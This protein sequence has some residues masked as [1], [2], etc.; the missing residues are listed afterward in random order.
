M[1]VAV[2]PRMAS[3]RVLLAQFLL[4]LIV[5]AGTSAHSAHEGHDCVHEEYLAGLPKPKDPETIQHMKVASSHLNAPTTRQMHDERSIGPNRHLMQNE[6]PP[7]PMR[8]HA[9]FML[10]GAD[11]EF[12]TLIRTRVIPRA[13]RGLSR[14]LRLRYPVFGNLKL[15][16]SC[17]EFLTRTR[18]CFSVGPLC[19]GA[20]PQDVPEDFFGDA[21]VCDGR[22][23][24]T[25]SGGQGISDADFAVFVSALSTSSCGPT[26]GAH[27]V[28]CGRDEDNWYGLQ[29]RPLVGY[30]NFCPPATDNPAAK[31]EDSLVD[32]AVHELI[33]TL[34]MS[35]NLYPHYITRDGRPLGVDIASEVSTPTVRESVRTHFN[36]DSAQGAPLEGNGGQATSGSHWEAGI[37]QSEIMIGASAGIQRRALSPVTLGL[38]QDSGWYEPNWDAVGFLRHGHNAGCNMLASCANEPG[39]TPAGQYFCNSPEDQLCLYHDTAAW[40]TQTDLTDCPINQ[41][42]R[43]GDCKVPANMVTRMSGTSADNVGVYY[44]PEAM[45]IGIP[46]GRL[47]RA[48]WSWSLTNACVASQCNEDGTLSVLIKNLASNGF[49]TH[50]CPEGENIDLSVVDG[51]Q[52]GTSL[53]PCPPVNEVCPYKNCPVNNG[54]LCSNQG[55][56]FEGKCYCA[57]DRSGPACEYRLCD[58]DDDCTDGQYCSEDHECS[59]GTAPPP[60]TPTPFSGFTPAPP[61]QERNWMLALRIGYLR[62]CVF[63]NDE[64]VDGSISLGETSQPSGSKGLVGLYVQGET[65]STTSPIRQDVIDTACVDTL[66]DKQNM[67]LLFQAAAGI[68]TQD[69]SVNVLSTATVLLMASESNMT[70]T[71]AATVVAEKTGVPLGRVHGLDWLQSLTNGDDSEHDAAL[72]TGLVS[73]ALIITTEQ[74]ASYIAGRDLQ[75]GYKAANAFLLYLITNGDPPM[76]DRLQDASWLVSAIFGTV[77]LLQDVDTA[78]EASVTAVADALVLANRQL[79]QRRS[80][81]DGDVESI[82][83]DW[84]K[85]AHSADVVFADSAAELREGELTTESYRNATSEASLEEAMARHDVS[86]PEATLIEEQGIV[87]KTRNQILDWLGEDHGGLY[88]WVWCAIG[89]ALLVGFCCCCTCINV[90]GRKAREE[91]F[92]EERML[93]Q[94]V[95]M[96]VAPP[97]PPIHMRDVPPAPARSTNSKGGYVGRSGVP[98]GVRMLDPNP[99]PPPKARVTMDLPLPPS[100]RPSNRRPNGARAASSSQQPHDFLAHGPRV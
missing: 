26:T 12:A 92:K 100:Q 65:T 32:T 64:N 39:Q 84:A 35:S 83:I 88:G 97:P 74:V 71:T 81:F 77:E 28:T 30:I 99:R 6:P 37:F 50:A 18:E 7:Q 89:V 24:R 69:S 41:P 45:C 9:E 27:A 10:D 90:R 57:V 21:E 3:C 16:R 62:S 14:L 42:L 98:S 19:W 20:L 22:G 87:E 2:R 61:A 29:D 54:L 5:T 56:C 60:T 15:P 52:P 38:A 4:L 82:A 70:R 25:I 40:C 44:G 86:L 31:G 23:C 36:C 11:P 46:G 43:N 79:V 66:T 75:L 48:G 85:I 58:T 76:M 94:Q 73:T 63:F 96:R 47:A 34:F 95:D 1:Q 91:A 55:H 72:D 51:F 59:G 67:T 13:M 49:T 8:M 17:S 80:E 93:R 68:P 53:G 78:D 33:H